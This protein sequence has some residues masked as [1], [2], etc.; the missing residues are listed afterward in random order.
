M[1][2][3][4]GCGC[5]KQ[6]ENEHNLGYVSELSSVYCLRCYRLKNF[7]EEYDDHLSYSEYKDIVEEELNRSESIVLVIDI[8]NLHASMNDELYKLIKN[9]KIYLLINKVDLFP[10]NVKHVKIIDWIEKYYNLNYKDILLVSSKNKLNIDQLILSLK[11]DNI[12][13]IPI[14]GMSNVGKSSLINVLKKSEDASFKETIVTSQISGTTLNCIT[15]KIKGINFIDTPGLI[16]PE[17]LQ[18]HLTK[19]SLK[20]LY[21]KKEYKPKVYQLNSE[22]TLFISSVLQLDYIEGERASFVIYCSDS[23]NIH[24]TSTKNVEQLREKHIFN[25]FF[26][27]PTNEDSKELKEFKKIEM[28]VK[29]NMNLFIDG[30]GWVKFTNKKDIMIAI[31]IPCLIGY[32]ISPSII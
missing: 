28:K 27:L 14:I 23:I 30:L 6:K 18:N 15:L 12:K 19:K 16:N 22:S 5:E 32:E 9:K 29:P 13:K 26:D 2:K 17:N 20:K 24:K 3:C 10:K 31:T 25:E 4:A 21:P 7:N 11:E 8:T 1:I